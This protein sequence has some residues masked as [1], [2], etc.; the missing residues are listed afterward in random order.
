MSNEKNT[1]AFQELEDNAL[2]QTVG[3]YL[4]VSQWRNYAATTLIPMINSQLGS[5]DAVDRTILNR[6]Y[7]IIQGTMVPG[8]SVVGAIGQL[9]SDYYTSRS[10]IHSDAVRSVL[11]RVVS[12][13]SN[14]MAVNA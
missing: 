10:N 2:E 3:G 13:A 7:S 1:K 6:V 8:A 12:L 4:H 14:Y 5:A 11:D 9:Q